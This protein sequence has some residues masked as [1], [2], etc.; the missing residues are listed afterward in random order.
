M[1]KP[2]LFSC[3]FVNQLFKQKEVVALYRAEFQDPLF[4]VCLLTY[5]EEKCT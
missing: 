3:L 4:K 1:K 2:I 5:Q